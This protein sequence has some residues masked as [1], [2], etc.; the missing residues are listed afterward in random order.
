MEK[1]KKL[2]QQ[3]NKEKLD[4]YVIPKTTNFLVNIYLRIMIDL[5]TFLIFQAHTVF[6]LF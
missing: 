5:I 1:I 4:G 6:Q 3:L 2:K